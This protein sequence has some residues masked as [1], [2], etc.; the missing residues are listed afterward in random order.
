M[1]FHCHCI[2]YIPAL[3]TTFSL[4]QDGPLPCVEGSLH[5]NSDDVC[6]QAYGHEDG[7]TNYPNKRQ[8]IAVNSDDMCTQAYGDEK[9]PT[10]YPNKV[11]RIPTNSDDVC[12][13]AYGNEDGATN[14]PNRGQG[15]AT[16][17]DDVCT[18]AYGHE[19]GTTNYHDEGGVIA[20]N[21]DDVCTQAYTEEESATVRSS[22]RKRPGRKRA[23]P[24]KF[25]LANILDPSS[26]FLGSNK[27]FF[28]CLTLSKIILIVEYVVLPGQILELQVYKP[29]HHYSTFSLSRMK[30]FCL[31][32]LN[33][34]N[35][36]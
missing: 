5:V 12:T 28:S 36:G 9:G 32:G 17:S 25:F 6:T 19:A 10:N 30:F 33:D 13:Q 22:P 2:D 35:I 23:V 21:S 27:F 8:G 1:A 3:N 11:Q 26:I 31:H 18:Q 29:K 15:I 16:N 4:M 34:A 7:A 24:S 20:T 14:Y